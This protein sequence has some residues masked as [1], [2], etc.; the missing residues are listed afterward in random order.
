MQNAKLKR[1]HNAMLSTFGGGFIALPVIIAVCA[2]EGIF[3]MSAVVTIMYVMWFAELRKWHV[4]HATE[5]LPLGEWMLKP[6]SWA[7]AEPGD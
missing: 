3:L 2:T 6:L 1:E 5:V 7:P 4:E